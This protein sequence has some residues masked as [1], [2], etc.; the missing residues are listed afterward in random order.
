MNKCTRC[1]GSGIFN[2]FDC[3]KCNGKG[4]ISKEDIA[5]LLLA[6]NPMKNFSFKKSV[7]VNNHEE[8]KQTV[9]AL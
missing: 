9:K 6:K 2:S 3:V 7:V 1:K 5:I 4:K 8:A